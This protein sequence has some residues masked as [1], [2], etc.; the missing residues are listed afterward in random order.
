LKILNATKG[1]NVQKLVSD[2]IREKAH[3]MRGGNVLLLSQNKFCKLT[4]IE[5]HNQRKNSFLLSHGGLKYIRKH[6]PER[7]K[8][9]EKRFLSGKWTNETPQTKIK[10]IAHNIRNRYT[11]QTQRH[12]PNQTT[13]FEA[14]NIDR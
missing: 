3:T 13:I 8:D 9:L 6:H 12:N 2:L 5:I 11:R 10:E 14:L 7:Y 4:G 1:A